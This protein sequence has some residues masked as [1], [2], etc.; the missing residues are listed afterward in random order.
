MRSAPSTLAVSSRVA[1]SGSKL[2]QP[3]TGL[4]EG[5]EGGLPPL[6]AGDIVAGAQE[7]RLE[8]EPGDAAP[9]LGD[10]AVDVVEGDRGRAEE[11]PRVG[12]AVAGQPVVIGA[13]QRQRV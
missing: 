3:L 13:V 1:S 4:P 11:A 2:I 7:G 5:L 9:Q 6:D 12:P 8:A 10:R